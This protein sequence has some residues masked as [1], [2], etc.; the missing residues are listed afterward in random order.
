MAPTSR[1]YLPADCHPDVLVSW[2]FPWLARDDTL[3]MPVARACRGTR[4]WAVAALLA[5]RR[6]ATAPLAWPAPLVAVVASEIAYCRRVGFDAPPCDLVVKAK[7]T[8][9]PTIVRLLGKG[10]LTSMTLTGQPANKDLTDLAGSTSVTSLTLS[11]LGA[12]SLLTAR[13][14]DTIATSAYAKTLRSLTI[15]VHLQE[16]A[17]AMPAIVSGCPL[18]EELDVNAL[19]RNESVLRALQVSLD[20]TATPA[21]GLPHMRTFRLGSFVAR[22][23]QADS[24]SPGDPSAF[25]AVITAAWPLISAVRISHCLSVTNASLRQLLEVRGPQLREL[26][27]RGCHVGDEALCAIAAHAEQLEMLDASLWTGG[28]TDAG[29]KALSLSPCRTSLK[30][31]DLSDLDSATAVTDRCITNTLGSFIGLRHV[32]VSSSAVVGDDALVALAS[33]CGWSLE[34]VSIWDCG[35]V[36]N[37]GLLALLQKSPALRHLNASKTSVTDALFAFVGDGDGRQ[38]QLPSASSGQPWTSNLTLLSLEHC[39]G[40]T[41]QGLQNAVDRMP[42]LAKLLALGTTRGTE[43]QMTTLRRSRPCLMLLL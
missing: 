26:R 38:D 13:C 42:A 6:D 33:C 28:L 41:V 32:D 39:S 29:L 19:N 20:T 36:G 15:D 9:I 27:F 34:W 1:R 2:T 4:S 11:S 21:R 18:L 24:A 16:L 3:V 43:A 12:T 23:A 22:P 7:G 31:I 17:G 35:K 37:P 10:A 40:I 25:A 30:W 8:S 5:T 14:I